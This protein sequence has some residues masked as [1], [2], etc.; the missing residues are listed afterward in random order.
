MRILYHIPTIKSIKYFKPSMMSNGII[1][2]LL[3]IVLLFTYL[4][5]PYFCPYP[6]QFHHQQA[7]NLLFRYFQA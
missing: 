4:Y 6:C 3:F 1:L 2:G 7:H 5:R